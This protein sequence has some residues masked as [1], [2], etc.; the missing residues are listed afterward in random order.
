V[1]FA[2][3]NA[4]FAEGFSAYTEE[5]AAFAW[6]ISP[7]AEECSAF[8]AANGAF[9]RASRHLGRAARQETRPPVGFLTSDI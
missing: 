8:A 5:S 1:P 3:V 4:P 7:L 6:G 2:W 9:A